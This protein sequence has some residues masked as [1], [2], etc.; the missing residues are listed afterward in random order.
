MVHA[1]TIPRELLYTAVC[2]TVATFEYVGARTDNPR[3]L[4]YTGPRGT[5][6]AISC[7]H[8]CTDNPPAPTRGP[9]SAAGRRSGAQE[10]PKGSQRESKDVPKQAHGTQK[11]PKGSQRGIIYLQTP[12]QP[13]QRTL[14]YIYIYLIATSLAAYQSYQIVANRWI[15]PHSLESSKAAH[16]YCRAPAYAVKFAFPGLPQHWH[17]QADLPRLPQSYQI[18]PDRSRSLDVAPQP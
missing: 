10:H 18:V 8:A 9:T 11:T 15:S 3:E 16:I 4:L 2:R 13:P 17:S 14:W 12:D 7:C 1:P 5:L 6:A